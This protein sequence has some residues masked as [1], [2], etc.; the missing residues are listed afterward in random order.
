MRS[1]TASTLQA[2]GRRSSGPTSL[3]QAAA[4][5]WRGTTASRRPLSTYS[6]EKAKACGVGTPAGRGCRPHT[7]RTTRTFD[8]SSTLPSESSGSIPTTIGTACLSRRSAPS[9]EAV[10]LRPCP[11]RKRC[12]APTAAHGHRPDS[13]R[14]AGSALPSACCSGTWRTYSAPP[15]PACT[16]RC[17]DT[18]ASPLLG[19]L[20]PL[21]H[22]LPVASLIRCLRLRC[23]GLRGGFLPWAAITNAGRCVVLGGTSCQQGSACLGQVAVRR[24]SVP[25]K[26]KRSGRVHGLVIEG[27]LAL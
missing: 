3:R 24:A 18:V 14:A 21:G 20:Q 23:V 16:R 10:C 26:L 5:S 11:S 9:T 17:N 2:T 27:S 4:V 25:L 19:Q 13:R 15:P 1:G 22:L 12:T 8:A 7:G 6:E